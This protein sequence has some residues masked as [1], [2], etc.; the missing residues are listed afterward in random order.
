MNTDIN[1]YIDDNREKIVSMLEEMVNMDSAS[2]NKKGADLLGDYIA[3]KFSGLGCEIEKDPQQKY[4]DHVICRMKGNGDNTL[5][6]GHFDTALPEGT[7]KERPFKVVDGRGYGPAAADMK[8]GIVATYFALK[9]IVENTDIKPNVT[10]IWN[11]DEEP[12]SP[13]SREV[14]YREAPKAARCFVME[15][16]RGGT[17]ITRRKGVGIFTFRCKGVAAHAGAEPEKGRS[18]IVEMGHKILELSALND[19][20]RGVTV[21]VGEIRGG[22]YPYVIAEEAV[23]RIDCRIPTKED[24]ERLIEKFN[25]IVAN[26]HVDGVVSEWE[27]RFHRPPMEKTSQTEKLLSLVLDVAEGLGLNIKELNSGGAS[28]ANLTSAMGIPTLCG[29]GPEGFG[30]HGIDEFVII[31]TL[32]ERTKLLAQTLYKI[33]S[34]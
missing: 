21:N 24:G 9:S 2:D 4:G 23:A 29:M 16:N 5:L 25:E 8:S 22:T 26:S 14:I 12:G 31:E 7:T 28:D 34:E 18:A 1:K 17:I 10:M 30:A 20:D 32:F 6:I 27:G 15:G 19:F 33:Y 13:T 3:S 11:S